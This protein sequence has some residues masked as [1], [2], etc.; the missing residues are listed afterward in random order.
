MLDLMN[1]PQAERP[2]IMK[3]VDLFFD[4]GW[5]SNHFTVAMAARAGAG[6]TPFRYEGFVSE[7]R[8]KKIMLS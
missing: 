4:H 5:P 1:I 6:L 8:Y 7:S 2:Q 3:G